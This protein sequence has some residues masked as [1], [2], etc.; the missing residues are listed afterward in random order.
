MKQILFAAALATVAI[1]VNA[2]PSCKPSFYHE[3]K[4]MGL[5]Q[6]A[7]LYALQWA[8]DADPHEY[9]VE[10]CSIASWWRSSGCVHRRFPYDCASDKT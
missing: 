7:L 5:D 2:E 6:E 9:V 1:P 10:I 3:M 4:N 8:T